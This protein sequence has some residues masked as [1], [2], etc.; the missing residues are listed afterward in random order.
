MIPTALVD[1]TRR[2]L[3]ISTDKGI[4]NQEKT[5]DEKIKELEKKV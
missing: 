2:Q 5:I 3:I 4:F 1:F